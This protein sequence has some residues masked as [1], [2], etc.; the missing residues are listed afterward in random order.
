MHRIIDSVSCNPF[1]MAS[2][3]KGPNLGVAVGG[4]S[5][6]LGNLI[7][8]GDLLGVLL[9]ILDNRFD[10]AVDAA[11]QIHRIASVC[12]A[13]ARLTGPALQHR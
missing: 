9:E 4:D 1:F 5:A 3:M 13:W 10:R 2:A 8:L 7:V 11:P 12:V 6:D